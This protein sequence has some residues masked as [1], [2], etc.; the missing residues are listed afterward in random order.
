MKK[1]KEFNAV[2]DFLDGLKAYTF[3]YKDPQ[4]ELK[5][6]P[7]GGEYLGVMAQDV[8]RTEAGKQI[9]SEG[10]DGVKRLESKPL[11]SAMAAGMGDLNERLKRLE[12]KR[13]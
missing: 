6:E 4:Y 13:G 12:K 10:P 2:Q 1:Q 8:E 9:V 3:R 11:M 7:N 5:S